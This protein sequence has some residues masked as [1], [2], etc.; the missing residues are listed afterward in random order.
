[1]AVGGS[2][3]IWF[4]IQASW[5]GSFV[6]QVVLQKHVEA[7]C[8][9]QNGAVQLSR[10]GGLARDLASHRWAVPPT[11]AVAISA[12]EVMVRPSCGRQGMASGV[13]QRA[14][15]VSRRCSTSWPVNVSALASTRGHDRPLGPTSEISVLKGRPADQKNRP[16]TAKSEN[17]TGFHRDR[18]HQSGPKVSGIGR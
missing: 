11:A 13:R 7:N 9:A 16:P 8:L 10:P 15:L 5:M 12:A 17:K 1:M 6:A 14:A 18:I 3:S 4:T 2:L